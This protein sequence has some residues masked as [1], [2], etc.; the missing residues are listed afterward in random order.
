[1][2]VCGVAAKIDSEDRTQRRGAGYDVSAAVA[3]NPVNQLCVIATLPLTPI[4]PLG[5]T[6]FNPGPALI[7]V[8]V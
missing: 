8:C 6:L 7:H 3:R 4:Q 5:G 1:M 2:M